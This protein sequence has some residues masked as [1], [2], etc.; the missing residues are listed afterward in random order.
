[1][2]RVLI[3]EDNQLLGNLYRSSLVA[4]GFAVEVSSD[5]ETGLSNAKTVPPDLILLDLMLPKKTGLDV[6]H[7][8]RADVN[9]Q[10]R[11][12]PAPLQ[13]LH[14]RCVD[15]K[16]L[17]DAGA[18]QVLVKAN[19][20]PKQIGRV[21]ARRA[22]LV[23]GTQSSRHAQGPRL[24]SRGVSL[25]VKGLRAQR[26]YD[27][28]VRVPTLHM[29]CQRCGRSVASSESFCG[30]CGARLERAVGVL[31]PP[32]DDAPTGF[33]PDVA[34]EA[35]PTVFANADETRL[36]PPSRTGGSGRYQT[37]AGYDRAAQA[38]IRSK[39][40]TTGHSRLGKASV[41]DITSSGC[42]ASAAWA[43]SIRPGMRSLR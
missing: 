28:P 35:A 5:G 33:E 38:E 12:G 24:E 39:G 31:T 8:I 14:A 7:S 41:V 23:A 21:G 15:R 40:P 19:T 6:L 29:V 25:T 3:I 43:P 37:C 30:R 27:L 26:C 10:E 42:W 32:P 2:K 36:S 1:M 4:A 18:T 20:T 9:A 11:A 17:W 16:E 22:W 13:R 34:A